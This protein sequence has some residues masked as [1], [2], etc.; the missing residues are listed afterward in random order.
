MNEMERRNRWVALCQRLGIASGQLKLQVQLY[1]M[2]KERYDEPHRRYHVIEHIDYC[3]AMLDEYR[4]M[5]DKPDLIE[6]AL[7]WHDAEY[8]TGKRP[9]RLP[10][11]ELL[12]AVCADDVLAQASH[13]TVYMRDQVFGLIMATTHQPGTAN[14]DDEK[15]I[16]DIDWSPLGCSW[17]EFQKNGRDIRYEYAS[18]SDEEFRYGRERFFTDALRR[19]SQF[20]LQPFHDRFEVH[21]VSNLTRGLDELRINA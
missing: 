8:R 12:S 1:H 14:T 2:L 17:K 16:A 9:G 15:L 4:H 6:Y 7:W 10:C 20:Y 5:A 3:L 13:S 18:I 21:A 11:N 19:Q